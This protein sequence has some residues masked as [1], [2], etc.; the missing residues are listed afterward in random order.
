MG[1]AQSQEFSSFQTFPDGA[2]CLFIGHSFFIPI[3]RQ[4]DAFA[5]E[6]DFPE[7]MAQF[8]FSGGQSGSPARLW[9]DA[10][11][12]AEITEILAE[13]NV[14]LFA[15][16]IHEGTVIQD[17]VRWIDLALTYNP[18]TS[19]FIGIPWNTDGPKG[20]L[21]ESELANLETVQLAERS[22]PQ[23][24]E[25]YPDHQIF[26][27]AY[28]GIASTM[29]SD[30]ELGNLP[31]VTQLVGT[32]DTSLHTD[33]FGHAGSMLVDMVAL[34]WLA[35]L[36]GAEVDTVVGST[37]AAAWNRDNVASITSDFLEFNGVV[38]PMPEVPLEVVDGDAPSQED[39]SG[40]RVGLLTY[41]GLGVVC[42]A[43]QLL[44]DTLV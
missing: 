12:K 44:I 30:F 34:S 24:R 3:A 31:D 8:V 1:R 21:E 39:S 35:I 9:N 11:H 17:Y 41:L 42:L 4:F 13:G 33:S 15:M 16:T 7:H 32:R 14:D 6:N 18:N 28:G 10:E 20:T 37:S 22:L 23:L 27:A 38:Q 40:T 36:Y 43:H 26:A 5:L 19:F 29:R 2:N 25:L